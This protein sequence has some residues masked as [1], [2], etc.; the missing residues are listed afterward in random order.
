MAWIAT[1]SPSVV[2]RGVYCS[3]GSGSY[4]GKVLVPV[5]AP[6]PVPVPK[7]D[8]ICTVFQQQKF[9]QNLAFFFRGSIVSQ[10]VV[11]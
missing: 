1:V 5:S 6:V 10:K 7:P 3:S 4:F 9:V 8:L 11:L 2:N